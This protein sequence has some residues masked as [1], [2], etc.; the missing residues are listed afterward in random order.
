MRESAAVTRWCSQTA[1]RIQR[2]S[3]LILVVA[4]QPEVRLTFLVPPHRRPVEQAVVPHGELD[5]T[6][7]GHISAVDDPVRKRVRAQARPLRDVGRRLRAARL[8]Y[9]LDGR[10]YLALQERS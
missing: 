6:R 1:L 8:G 7:A 3:R 4:A 10:G 5:P 2:L 9:L